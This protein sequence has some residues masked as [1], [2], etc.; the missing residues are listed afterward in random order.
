[1]KGPIP[2]RDLLRLVKPTASTEAN[3]AVLA[4]YFD[5]SGTHA[6]AKVAVWAGFMAPV[7]LWDAFDGERRE[8]LARWGLV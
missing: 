1:M 4:A 5:D 2:F 6:S 7:P 8:L 3:L